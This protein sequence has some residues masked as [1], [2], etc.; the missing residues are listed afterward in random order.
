M[1]SDLISIDEMFID[2]SAMR[3]SSVL[4]IVSLVLLAGCSSTDAPLTPVAIAGGKVVGIPIG[5]NGPQPGRSNGYEVI[6]AAI[7]PGEQV[8]Q[9]V[10]K[11]AFSAPPSVKLTRVVVDDIS[12]EQSSPM[13]DDSQPW[14]DQNL[15]RSERKPL[16]CK[17]PLL[18]W[19]YTVTPSMRVYRFLITDSTGKQ[20][21]LYQLTGYPPY[22]K[23]AMRHSFGEK[24]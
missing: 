12:D 4:L 16:D 18:A 3:F 9:L 24:Y 23:S 6:Y 20:T 1:P 22:V 8:T 11:F 2:T 5:R 10:Y 7:V 14:L 15:W 19:I 17:D 13:I 21:T